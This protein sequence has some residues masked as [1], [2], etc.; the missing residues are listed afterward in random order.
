MSYNLQYNY[1][2]IP[3]M[4]GDLKLSEKTMIV[5]SHIEPPVIEPPVSEPPVTEPPV[6]E[7]ETPI[8]PETPIETI[9]IQLYH[10]DGRAMRYEE[11]GTINL[12]ST[13]PICNFEVIQSV[14]VMGNGEGFISL[15]EITT[16]HFLYNDNLTLKLKPFINNIYL[17]SFKIHT[18]EMGYKFKN[19]DP[20]GEFAS[21]WWLNYDD[22]SDTIVL[23]NELSSL[24]WDTN[25]QPLINDR[26][27]YIFSPTNY[28]FNSSYYF[29]NIIEP[30]MSIESV[31][32]TSAIY[33]QNNYLKLQSHQHLSKTFDNTDVIFQHED[34]QI[35]SISIQLYS[36][37]NNFKIAADNE[38]WIF[39]LLNGVLSFNSISF[40]IPKSFLYCFMRFIPNIV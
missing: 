5:G 7:P 30:L 39:Q 10:P 13:N 33:H 16:G 14:S 20:T 24:T 12:N 25:E 8:D 23:N 19:N 34:K 17:F 31:V 29:N 27:K 22:A 32:D 26:Y 28:R 1:N 3:T 21:N 15:R 9:S 37:T 4:M 6:T 36:P 38:A 40:S 18:Y 11:D 2:K 35:I